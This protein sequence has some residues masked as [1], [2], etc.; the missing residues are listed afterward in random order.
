MG[1]Y[2]FTSIAFPAIG[3]GKNG[4]SL[5]IAVRT[6]VREMKNQ[7]IK[8]NLSWTVKFIIQSHQIEI[9]DEFRK[10][11]LTTSNGKDKIFINYNNSKSYS[12]RFY[13]ITNN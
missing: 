1:A 3:C 11:V 2:N 13:G 10:Q 5:D 12:C 7:L 6:V 4:C 9:Y 8:R